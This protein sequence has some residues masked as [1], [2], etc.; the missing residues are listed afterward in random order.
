MQIP[1]ESE[2][3]RLSQEAFG[4][5]AR[6]LFLCLATGILAGNLQLLTQLWLTDYLEVPP[7]MDQFL[8]EDRFLGRSLRPAEDK[9]GIWPGWSQLLRRDYDLSGLSWPATFFCA[10]SEFWT[11]CFLV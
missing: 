3:Q 9:T 6:Q 7:A 4:A 10:T 1:L 2:A 11:D 8:F 5:D